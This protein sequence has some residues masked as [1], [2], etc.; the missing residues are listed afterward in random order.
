MEDQQQRPEASQFSIFKDSIKA[1]VDQIHSETRERLP[2]MA[3]SADADAFYTDEQV[4]Q[5]M[6]DANDEVNPRVTRP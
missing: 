4:D 1:Q 3:P 6:A 2:T 5:L